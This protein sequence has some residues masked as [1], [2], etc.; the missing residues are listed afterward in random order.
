MVDGVGDLPDEAGQSSAMRYAAGRRRFRLLVMC[1]LVLSSFAILLTSYLFARVGGEGRERRS[2]IC[3][4][5]EGTHET[6]VADLNRTYAFLESLPREDYGT[7][8]TVAVINGL[9][10]K[11]AAVRG[12]RLTSDGR[13]I[14]GEV[15]PL[16]C[17]DEG[18]GL[19]E[20]NPEI[21]PKRDFSALLERP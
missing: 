1:S 17:N 11:E 4:I 9:P 3:R 12:E 18:I 21:P 10:A 7:P 8:L 19:P 2:A 13:T 5:M 14:R 6:A 15:V 20:P 16:F